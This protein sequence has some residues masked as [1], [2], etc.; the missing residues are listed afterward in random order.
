[1]SGK[2]QGASDHAGWPSS[3]QPFRHSREALLLDAKPISHHDSAYSSRILK[4]SQAPSLAVLEHDKSGTNHH[5][6]EG[7]QPLQTTTP[8]VPLFTVAVY[9]L[10]MSL[11]S[12]LGAVPFFFVGVLSK[13]WCGFA[14][15]IACGVMLAASFG[16]LQEGA[17][18]GGCYVIAG[19]L[20][21]ALFIKL[22]QQYL[23]Q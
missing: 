15:A 20:L 21:G 5:H 14:N 23:E 10:L 2:P 9:T 8:K 18:Y 11:A 17:P 12:G 1:M 13:P 4:S 19:M 22:S 6:A 3:A 7:L 16:L